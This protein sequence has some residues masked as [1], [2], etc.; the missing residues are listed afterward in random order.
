M[1]AKIA[2]IEKQ[3][4]RGFRRM[5]ADQ[6]RLEIAVSSFSDHRIIRSLDHPIS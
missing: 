4:Y 2:E 3:T 1:I 5:N 6:K